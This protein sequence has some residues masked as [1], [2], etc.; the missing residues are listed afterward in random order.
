MSLGFSKPRTRKR[1]VSGSF[2]NQCRENTCYAHAISKI[3]SRFV[4]VTYGKIFDVYEN[5]ETDENCDKLFAPTLC[6]VILKCMEDADVNCSPKNIVFALLYRIFYRILTRQEV[7]GMLSIELIFEFCSN[8]TYKRFMDFWK[9][10]ELYENPEESEKLYSTYKDYLM[11]VFLSLIHIKK[12]V[13]ENKIMIVTL[14]PDAI[15]KSR[16][17]Y[18]ILLKRVLSLGLYAYYGTDNHAMTIVDVDDFEHAFIVK[19][20]WGRENNSFLP[21]MENGKISFDTF[22]NIDNEL[23]KILKHIS[24]VITVEDMESLLGKLPEN[25]SRYMRIRGGKR[26]KLKRKGLLD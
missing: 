20:S 23:S 18:I 13:N 8:L 15:Y 21:I 16:E 12:L 22:G 24:F 19:N 5:D 26:T 11:T 1:R 4:L 7:G 3:L 2:S 25:T 6:P 17:Y 14:Y 10:V 9:T